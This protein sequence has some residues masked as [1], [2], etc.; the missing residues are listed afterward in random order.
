MKDLNEI[1]HLRYCRPLY[2]NK[3]RSYSKEL[4]WDGYRLLVKVKNFSPEAIKNSILTAKD[5]ISMYFWPLFHLHHI[6]TL[7][8]DWFQSY[9]KE[10]PSDGSGFDNL[11]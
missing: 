7:Y 5:P 11:T 2:Y 10:L 9:S 8:Y 1:D 4:H 3:L 6:R